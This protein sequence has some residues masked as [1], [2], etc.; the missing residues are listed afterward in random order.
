[1]I[2]NNSTVRDAWKYSTNT[3][4]R[5]S[6]MNGGDKYNTKFERL[7]TETVL[8][9]AQQFLITIQISISKY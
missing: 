1:M 7:N 9:T 5:L 6:N 3:L 4:Q 8:I 2:N